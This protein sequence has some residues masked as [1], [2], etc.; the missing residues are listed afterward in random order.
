M[1]GLYAL[2][3][4]FG[5]RIYSRKACQTNAI[6]TTPHCSVTTQCMGVIKGDPIW[7]QTH[8]ESTPHNAQ[9]QDIRRGQQLEGVA[10]HVDMGLIYLTNKLPSTMKCGISHLHHQTCFGG[11]CLWSFDTSS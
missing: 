8:K 7:D 4:H 11:H 9:Y 2:S 1:N 10:D 3:W 6:G 5:I